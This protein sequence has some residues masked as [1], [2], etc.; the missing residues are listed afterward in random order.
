MEASG[1]ACAI[2]LLLIQAVLFAGLT[3]DVRADL[4][5]SCADDRGEGSCG[6]ADDSGAAGNYWI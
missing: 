5:G 6:S 1:W 4:H 3:L 2:M